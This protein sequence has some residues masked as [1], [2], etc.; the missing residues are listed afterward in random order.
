MW[1][2]QRLDQIN[3]F[4]RANLF[5]FKSL[6]LKIQS[7]QIGPFKTA[8][9]TE[10]LMA[11]SEWGWEADLNEAWRQTLRVSVLVLERLW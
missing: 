1:R 9:R 5:E 4:K 11:V 7:E 3:A 8:I 10:S 6:A 2:V